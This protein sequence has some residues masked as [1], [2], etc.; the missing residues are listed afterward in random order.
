MPIDDD[1][2]GDVLIAAALV[3]SKYTR[4]PFTNGALMTLL[5]VGALERFN[6]AAR[7]YEKAYG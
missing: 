6:R 1:E 3:L 7:N 2:A 5:P 4:Q